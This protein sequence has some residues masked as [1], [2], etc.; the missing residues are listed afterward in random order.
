MSK[1]AIIYSRVSTEEQ[2]EKGTSLSRQIEECRRYAVSQGLEIVAELQDNF[3]GGTLERPGFLELRSLLAEG[4]A[5]AV[6]VFRQDRLSRD[7]ADYMYLR[8]KWGK[9]GIELHFCDRG[10]VSY[11]FAG[12]VLDSTMSGVNE[13]ERWLIRDRTTDGR[14]KKARDK[15]KPVMSGIPPYGCR[16]TG[17]GE[18]AELHIDNY[19]SL[20]VQEIFKWYIEGDGV[21]GSLSLRA[22]A[23]KLIEQ[24]IKPPSYRKRIA[25]AW[26]SNTVRGIITN[27]I[28]IGKIYYGKTTSNWGERTLQPRDKWIEIEVPDLAFIDRETFRAAGKKRK[29]NKEDNWH[30]KKHKYL[31]TG[32]IRCGYCGYA[33]TGNP[34]RS[35]NNK[36]YLN[37][38][39]GCSYKPHLNCEAGYKSMRGQKA[40]KAVWDWLVWLLSDETNLR[41]GLNELMEKR[42]NDLDPK[43]EKF[44]TF[45]ELLAELDSRT[46]RLVKE[47]SNNDDEVVLDAIRIQLK[48]IAKQHDNLESKKIILEVELLNLVID[49]ETEEQIYELA[50]RV[51]TRLPNA[52]F[53]EKKRILEL[54]DVQ[55]TI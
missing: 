2:A 23:R 3:S 50:S 14:I 18:D 49:E 9:D 55:V 20:I 38:R 52:T 45:K 43:I 51:R 16:R 10:K 40:D 21:N 32:R 27:E 39:C 1:N 17:K 19:E 47:L 6:I 11:D 28:Y 41:K 36:L 29:R 35:F 34:R 54:L 46:Q 8:K 7:S 24:E 22:I 13:G 53:E 44:E 31:L 4:N 30:E 48:E 26:Y 5:N 37:Y 42:R 15:K 33:A 25:K 12:I